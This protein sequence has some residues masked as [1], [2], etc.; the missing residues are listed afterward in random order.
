[1]DKKKIKRL[2][3]PYVDGVTP[4]TLDFFG[5]KRNI[6]V[7]LN[8]IVKQ[9]G[10]MLAA[11]L[12]GYEWLDVS[13]L[14]KADG[15][16]RNLVEQ[17]HILIARKAEQLL[18]NRS[19]NGFEEAIEEHGEIVKK[20]RKFNDKILLDYVKAHNPKYR[21]DGTEDEMPTIEI[22]RFEVPGK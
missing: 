12:L 8:E 4:Q 20:S 13:E 19:M 5:N 1:M 3:Y 10:D 7:F 2:T 17:Q 16:L 14:L 21:K 11:D 22:K 15:I 18:C 6:V 9:G